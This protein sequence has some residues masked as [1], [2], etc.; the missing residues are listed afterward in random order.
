[1]TTIVPP[2]RTKSSKRAFWARSPGGPHSPRPITS[3]ENFDRSTDSKS[4][5]FTAM[6]DAKKLPEH[7]VDVVADAGH[8][9]N[10][11]TARASI[12]TDCR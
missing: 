3:V 12:A 6:R 11:E 2:L 7:R 9:G 10:D 1:M 8:V 5:A 4:S